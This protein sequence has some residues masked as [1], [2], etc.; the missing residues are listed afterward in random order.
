MMGFF[1]CLFVSNNDS[2]NWNDQKV[3]ILNSLILYGE[4]YKQ[5]VHETTEETTFKKKKKE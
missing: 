2:G 1:V 5:M 3:F 4:Y